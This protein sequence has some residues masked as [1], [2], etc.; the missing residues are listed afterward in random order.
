MPRGGALRPVSG[1]VLAGRASRA[2]TRGD[3]EVI[4]LDHGITVYP[5]RN[6][7]GRWRAVWQEAGKRDQCE[8]A[9]EEKLAAK[10]EKVTARLAADAPNMRRPGADLITHYLHPDRLPVSARWSRKHAHT[11]Q[12]LCERFAAPV[13][14]SVAC[15]DIKTEHTQAIVNAAPT[16][17]EGDRVR[18]MISALVTVGLDG[19]YLANPRLAKVHWQAGDRA[20]PAPD[21]SVA[22]ESVLW[23][24]PGEIPSDDDVVK[25]GQALAAGRHGDRDELMAN[26][27][28]YSGLRWG[29][30]TALTISQVDASARTITVDR[31]VVEVA[32]HLYVEAPKNRKRRRTIYPRCTP[33]GYPL[34]DKLAAR[35]VAAR[36]EQ[37]AGT[38]PLGLLYPSPTGKYWRSSNFQR[39]VLKRAYLAVGWR[40]ADVECAWTWHSLRHVFCTTALFAWKLDATDVARMA[41]H[42]NYRITLDMYVGSTAGVLDRARTATE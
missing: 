5:A 11:Q 37:A 6:E 28:A 8:A 15:Q 27:A 26:A 20:L 30:L 39:N 22:G 32:G 1:Q 10:L 4:E 42:S 34:A 2:A 25:L 12:R 24:E 16:A 9:T 38:N 17:G 35:V 18:G 23:I 14:A 21:V 19:G 41:G 40:G 29:E 36:S 7:H 13:I 33:G 3:G 31:K